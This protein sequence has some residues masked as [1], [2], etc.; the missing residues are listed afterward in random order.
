M[1]RKLMNN[2]RSRP[3]S[4]K[5]LRDRLP[6]NVPVV[7][8]TQLRGKHR[9]EVFKN[10]NAVVVIIPLKGTKAGHFVVLLPR[11]NHISYFSSL[12]LGPFDELKKLHE[13]RGIFEDLLGKH[14]V[15]NRTKLQANRAD[16]QSCWF[17]VLLRVKF[18]D[19]KNRDFV[20]LFTTR[21]SLN[22]PDDVASLMSL[23]LVY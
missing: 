3:A 8:Y 15:Y 20:S 14:Y 23:P 1:L 2:L 19:L 22:S 5:F 4:V 6:K 7:E 21:T 11:K 9:S 12:G 13:P 16:T 17:W 10:K 18:H